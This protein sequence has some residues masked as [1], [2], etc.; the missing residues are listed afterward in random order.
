MERMRRKPRGPEETGEK[1]VRKERNVC[2]ME[3]RHAW[4]R[5]IAQRREGANVTKIYNI[6]SAEF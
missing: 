5:N 2:R 3:K 4:E 1:T 6:Y